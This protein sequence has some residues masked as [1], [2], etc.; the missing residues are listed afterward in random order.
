MPPGTASDAHFG[1]V[2]G[3]GG[4]WM[5]LGITPDHLDMRG[6]RLDWTEVGA[7]GSIQ[8]SSG[9]FWQDLR[10]GTILTFIQKEG[11]RSA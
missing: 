1:R 9:S 7:S 3:N 5:E 2:L 11:G 10:I 6:W 4:D 8:L